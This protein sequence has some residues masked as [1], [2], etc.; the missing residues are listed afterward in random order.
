MGL[1]STLVFNLYKCF[2]NP[3]IQICRAKIL[4]VKKLSEMKE[5]EFDE[6]AS[7]IAKAV[8]VEYDKYECKSIGLFG[9][10]LITAEI[11]V[12]VKKFTKKPTLSIV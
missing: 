6:F 7:S 3:N 4:S 11:L 2:Q 12:E 5:D 10:K 8:T 9:C 1:I